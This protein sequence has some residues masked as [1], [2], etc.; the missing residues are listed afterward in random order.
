MKRFLSMKFLTALCATVAVSSNAVALEMTGCTLDNNKIVTLSNLDSVPI[1][2]Y[3]TAKKNELT[4][5]QEIPG[6]NV[7]KKQVMFSGGGAEY[8]R[9]Q[10]GAY[11]Y[12]AYSGIGKGWN[13]IGLIVYKGHKVIMS[14]SCKNY[15]NALILNM[16]TINAQEDPSEEFLYAP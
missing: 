9:F 14:Q 3:G 10:K 15:D 16:E 6:V 11:S 2:S 13:F 1:Y 4:L 8:L 12:V 5:S 7:Y